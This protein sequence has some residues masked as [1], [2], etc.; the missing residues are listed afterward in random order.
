MSLRKILEIALRHLIAKERPFRLRRC[1][2]KGTGM[3]RDFTHVEMLH[4]M[5]GDISSGQD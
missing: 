1:P 4:L 5:Y 3:V 2:F